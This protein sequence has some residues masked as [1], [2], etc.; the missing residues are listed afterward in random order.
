LQKPHKYGIV[1]SGLLNYEEK[2]MSL[3]LHK[4]F[5]QISGGAVCDM[6]GTT[7][8]VL[9]TEG[10]GFGLSVHTVHRRD[11]HHA[12]FLGNV[13][14]RDCSKSGGNTITV[15]NADIPCA[16]II[17]TDPV[18]YGTKDVARIG[19]ALVRGG[20]GGDD[21]FDRSELTQ[22]FDDFAKWEADTR[23]PFRERFLEESVVSL[24]GVG[25]RER[26]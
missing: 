4:V 9:S 17:S 20:G 26:G 7:L 25:A 23:R 19:E 18:P 6:M 24:V 3:I 1:T 12:L 14:S 22:L 15:T 11:D 16:L 2:A 5:H 13:A 10:I 21:W 8:I